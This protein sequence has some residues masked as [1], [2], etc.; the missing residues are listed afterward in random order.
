MHEIVVATKNEGKVTEIRQVLR[1]LPVQILSLKDFGDLP[2]AIEDGSTFAEN[3]EKKARHYASL[4]GKPCLADDSGLEVD[5]LGG[6]PGVFSARYAGPEATDEE[7]NIKLLYLMKEVFPEKRT[8]RFRCCLA[9]FD[10]NEANNKTV[11]LDG[12]CEGYIG[13]SPK[14]DGGFGYDPLFYV[15]QL[16]ST[17]AELTLDAK[18]AISHR[19]QALQKFARF[20]GEQVK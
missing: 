1:E 2:E 4:T 18:N 10:P 13:Y 3:A 11:I 9:Y 14:G 5:A 15:P 6:A 17:M 16:H 7:N 19:G 8:G 12:A 20:L